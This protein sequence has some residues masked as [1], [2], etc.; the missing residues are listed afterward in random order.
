M[1]DH[2]SQKYRLGAGQFL[3]TSLA[4]QRCKVWDRNKEQER[5]SVMQRV[6]IKGRFCLAHFH[7]RRQGRKCSLHIQFHR[8]K[9]SLYS[10]FMRNKSSR[11]QRACLQLNI[12]QRERDREGIAGCANRVDNAC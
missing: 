7:V 12:Y 5:R 3:L 10:P 2:L 8:L 4:Q 9:M 11:C 6:R 1:A